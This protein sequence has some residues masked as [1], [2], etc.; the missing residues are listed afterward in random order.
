MKK[1]KKKKSRLLVWSLRLKEERRLRILGPKKEEVVG[2]WRRLHNEELHNLY[3]LPDIIRIIISRRMRWE[4]HVA[5]M[6]EMRNVYIILVE[7]LERSRHRWENNIKMDL[8]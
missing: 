4:C 1:K 8:G 6:E 3:F 5:R 2:D 7:K